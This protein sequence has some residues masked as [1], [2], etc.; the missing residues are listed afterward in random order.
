MPRDRAAYR[1]VRFYNAS[2]GAVVGGFFQNGSITEENLIWILSDVLLIVEERHPWTIRHR[3]SER[4]ITPSSNPVLGDY[5]TYSTGSIQVTNEAWFVRLTSHSVSG[6]KD[7]FR[8]GVRARDGNC[9]ISGQVNPGPQ[10]DDWAGFEA[11]H[12]FPLE[13]ESLWIEFNYGRWIANMDDAVGVSKI[14]SIQNGLLM[15][16][17]LHTLFDQYLFSVNPDDGYKIVEVGPV[18]WGIDRGVLDPVCRDPTTNSHVSDELLRWHF[19]QSVLAN[20]R[21]A[22]EPIF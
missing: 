2:T 22:G 21:G 1:N 7:K 5:D 20:M 18:S 8:D 9:V 10:W 13:K 3:V 15:T 12:V 6:G 11:V 19:R 4:V 14:H 17:H 16:G